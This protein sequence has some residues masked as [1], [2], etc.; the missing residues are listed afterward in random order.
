MT[1]KT[2]YE[3]DIETVERGVFDDGE[4]YADIVNH[5]HHD[6]CPGIPTHP[7]DMLVLVR[8][9]W[10]NEDGYDELHDRTWA[11]V[12]SGKLPTHFEDGHKVPK[13]FH[14]EL[15]KA[16]RAPRVATQ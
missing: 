4:E 5:D 9:V 12:E 8:D 13:R 6:E 7:D 16:S 10:T 15:A 11:Y 2:F 14:V 3:W 1:R